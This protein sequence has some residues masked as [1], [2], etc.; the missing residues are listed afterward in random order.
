MMTLS[1]LPPLFLPCLCGHD[2]DWPE[3]FRN[4]RPL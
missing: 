3:V 2:R 1:T 4:G